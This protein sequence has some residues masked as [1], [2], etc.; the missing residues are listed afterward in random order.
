ME[1]SGI[2]TARK[3]QKS[4]LASPDRML[5]RFNRILISQS[6]AM[7]GCFAFSL[8]LVVG[9][10]DHLSG[11]E[12]SFSVFYLLPIWIAAWY[13]DRRMG[14]L[15]CAMSGATWMIVEQ[16]TGVAYSQNWVLFW[17]SAVR[18]VFFIVVAYL[19]AELRTQLNRQQDL[20]RTDNL[21]GLLNRSGFFERARIIVNAASR[22]GYAIAIAYIDI[23]NFKRINDT[24]G[25]SKGDEALKAVAS[26]LGGSS[27]DSD[28]VARFGGDEF[29]VLLPDT[30]LAG[31]HA[32]FNKLHAELQ[33]EIHQQGWSTLG[34][35]IGAVVCEQAPADISD[36]LRLA[37]DLMYRR[38][39]AGKA[40]VIVEAAH[41][42]NKNIR[43]GTAVDA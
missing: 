32:Y 9:V 25:H 33:S 41:Q 40:G 43:R 36:A 7:V 37:D 19:I 20:A 38:K 1:M 34:F 18:L 2:V 16:T 5:R 23:D 21:T 14:Y 11:Y 8:V 15:A 29:V 24:L 13:G 22:Y 12:L 4:R 17:N 42:P 26:L 30:S 6:A 10:I 39:R 31:A 35:S 3:M 28:A 27:R